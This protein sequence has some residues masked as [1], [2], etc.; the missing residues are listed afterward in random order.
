MA[1]KIFD[2]ND[3]VT[4]FEPGYIYELRFSMGGEHFPFYVGETTD[5]DR[6]LGEHQYGARNADSDSEAKYQF[7]ATALDA[8]SIPWTMVPVIEYGSEGPEAL[9]DEHMM[10]LLVDGYELTNAK[11]GNANWMAERVAVADDMRA[12][13]I[14]S[15]KEYTALIAAEA[16]E[17]GVDRRTPE[18]RTQLV[19]LMTMVKGS[20]EAAL[21]WTLKHEKRMARLEKAAREREVDQFEDR[22]KGIAEQTIQMTF[23]FPIEEQISIMQGLVFTYQKDTSNQQLLQIAQ[24]RLEEL[25]AEAK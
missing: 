17:G 14:R 16:V 21:A 3:K 4:G 1:K 24:L 20:A 6:R 12:R 18:Q 9:E 25:Q 19:N 23:Q 2:D 15:F 7:I 5:P 22:L 10:K 11:K 13:D 8:N